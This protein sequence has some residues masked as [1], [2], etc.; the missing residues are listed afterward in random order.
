MSGNRAS[1]LGGGNGTMAASL[2][3]QMK[4]LNYRKTCPLKRATPLSGSGVHRFFKGLKFEISESPHAHPP[5][6]PLPRR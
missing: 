6:H 3:S 5:H 1:T 2:K 4:T